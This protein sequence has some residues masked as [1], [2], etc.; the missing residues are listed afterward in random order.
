MW[1][2]ESRGK[3]DLGRSVG[4]RGAL[5]SGLLADKV[6][7]HQSGEIRTFKCE[8]SEGLSIHQPNEGLLQS[9]ANRS[10]QEPS[11]EVIA[12]TFGAC[13]PL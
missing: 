2:G 10:A 7:L 8:S 9:A 11:S 1:N 6:P 5:G 13:T 3:G 12:R 4:G